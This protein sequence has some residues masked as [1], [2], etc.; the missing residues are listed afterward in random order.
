MKYDVNRWRG[1]AQQWKDKCFH[2]EQS[3]QEHETREYLKLLEKHRR[4]SEELERT[5]ARVWQL[6]KQ[7]YG[8]KTEKKSVKE[9]EALE[10][11]SAAPKKKRGAQRGSKGHGRTP[12]E[13][14][15]REVETLD[16]APEDQVCDSCG[17]AYEAVKVF[18]FSWIS[19][20]EQ[21]FI[22]IKSMR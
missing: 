13:K 8:R 1:L 7:V 22:S 20:S 17:A 11:A 15:P 12:R 6:E 19:E 4:Q 5:K 16:V 2:L 3:Q 10:P 14:L 18:S 9:S 21:I